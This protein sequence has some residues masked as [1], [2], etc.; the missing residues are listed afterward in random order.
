MLLNVGYSRCCLCFSWEALMFALPLAA[1][2][3]PLTA[4]GEH[5]CAAFT[6]RQSRSTSRPQSF[7]L[8]CSFRRLFSLFL[9]TECPELYIKPVRSR[10]VRFPQRRFLFRLSR[11]ASRFDVFYS[12]IWFVASRK[13]TAL[14][15]AMRNPSLMKSCQFQN[16]PVVIFRHWFSDQRISPNFFKSRLRISPGLSK[17]GELQR[18]QQLRSC[19]ENLRC[20]RQLRRFLFVLTYS[21]S[22]SL[23]ILLRK[24]TGL[25][26]RVDSPRLRYTNDFIEAEYEY[27]TTSVTETSD[28]NDGEDV[29]T[30][31]AR[32][33]ICWSIHWKYAG[34]YHAIRN[35]YHTKYMR[36]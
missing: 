35:V 17:L 12:F 34:A 33:S 27:Q 11:K 31:S 36:R 19:V 14:S 8:L 16:P 29:Y 6:F 21:F 13:I 4:A 32:L 15:H 28:N 30:V 26:V 18:I 2:L 5:D 1:R 25:K 9:D 7:L 10:W 23:H 3:R 20:Y 24:M 22:L